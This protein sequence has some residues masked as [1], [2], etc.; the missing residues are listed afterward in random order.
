MEHQYTHFLALNLNEIVKVKLEISKSKYVGIFNTSHTT[1]FI[2]YICVIIRR[3][4]NTII[5]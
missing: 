3:I 4:S 5:T 2:V 1:T